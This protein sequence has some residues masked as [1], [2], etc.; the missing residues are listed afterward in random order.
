MK[1]TTAVATCFR[2]YVVFSGRARR[3][4]FWFF[5]LFCTIVNTVLSLIFGESAFIPSLISLAMRAYGLW[6]IP[7]HWAHPV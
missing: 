7:R 1:F 2:K 6:Q 3:S 5:W 4:E